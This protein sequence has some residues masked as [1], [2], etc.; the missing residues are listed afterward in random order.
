MFNLHLR[1]SRFSYRSRRMEA[2]V[3]TF[4]ITNWKPGEATRF[5]YIF[6][7]GS[8]FSYAMFSRRSAAWPPNRPTV[9]FVSIS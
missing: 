5:P 2:P 8:R 3:R 1:D 4:S 9:I 6:D 7:W